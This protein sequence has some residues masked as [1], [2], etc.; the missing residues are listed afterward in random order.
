MTLLEE[1]IEAVERGDLASV[2]HFL[3]QGLDLNSDSGSSTVLYQVVLSL[4]DERTPH[5]YEIM[6]LILESGADP[7]FRG[8]HDDSPLYQPIFNMDT[9]MLRLLLEAGADLNAPGLCDPPESFYDFSEFDY[10]YEVWD[11]KLPINEI[12][13]EEKKDEE[14]W[15][16]FLDRM[17]VK[18]ER[19]RPD[20]LFLLRKHGA[21]TSRE[22]SAT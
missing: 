14:G 10:R 20:Y 18:Y 3:S 13:E 11:G 6:K 15:L 12:T 7:N 5:R 2:S 19:R 4:C 8:A 17:A 9:E 22:N 21:K 16:R 1:L